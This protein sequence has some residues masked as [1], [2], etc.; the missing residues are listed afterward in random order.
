[1]HSRVTVDGLIKATARI[2]V[3]EGFDKAC[4]NRIAGVRIGSPDQYYPDDAT[5]IHQ[6]P[7]S[8]NNK[9][10]RWLVRSCEKQEQGAEKEIIIRYQHKSD[11]DR[12]GVRRAGGTRFVR[13]NLDEKVVNVKRRT[14]E[15]RWSVD[16]RFRKDLVV[17]AF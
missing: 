16:D 17:G 3:R 7:R 6:P 14:I 1:L 9:R 10:R 13:K 5:A 15:N 8:S 4:T 12:I 2:L 11:V